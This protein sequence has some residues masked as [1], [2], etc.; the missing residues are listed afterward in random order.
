MSIFG[1]KTA[2][3][4]NVSPISEEAI[5][6]KPVTKDRVIP[7]QSLKSAV[8]I[9]QPLVSEKAMA[10]SEKNT[11]VF[12]VDPRVN[13]SEVRKEIENLYKVD[14]IK[15]NT[16]KYHQKSRHFK[17][18]ASSQKLMKKAMVTLK[19]GQKIEIFNK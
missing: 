8:H 2:K 10:L 14:V 13:K 12:L 19:S 15:I 5:K 11:Y 1:K 4:K 6:A 17:G 7:K 18:L 9:I 16:S 3:P